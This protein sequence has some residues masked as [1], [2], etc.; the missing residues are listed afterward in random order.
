MKH[1]LP[2]A[3]AGFTLVELAIVMVIIGLIV[4][5]IIAGQSIIRGAEINAVVTESRK[6]ITAIGQFRDKYNNLPGD[7]STASSF[8]SGMGNGD[9]DAKIENHGTA[10]NNEI[11]LFWIHLTNAGLVEGSYTNVGD[12]TTAMNMGTNNPK[13]KIKGG[14]WNVAYLGTVDYDSSSGAYTGVR[15]PAA[16][17]F[18]YGTY[19][20]VLLLGSGTNALLP[21]GIV[22]PPEAYNI[23][24][25]MDDG[26]PDTGDLTTLESQGENDNT[27][28][29][30]QDGAN[31]ALA[32]SS[33]VLTNNTTS[34]CSLV[35]KTGF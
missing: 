22:S 29:S 12:S 17:T 18:F 2:R 19:E 15:S 31:T 13:S 5:G 32:A 26:K 24:V 33:Y 6:Y 9:G 25:K 28:C 8:W 23:D 4:G 16:D 35:F 11:S 30:N 3:N 21:G 27:R 1:P 10:A 20:H 14:G 7:F 34:A